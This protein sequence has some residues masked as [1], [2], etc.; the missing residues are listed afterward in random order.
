M[1][2]FLSRK[3][4][5][6]RAFL[7]GSG[8]AVALPLLDAMTPA[9]ARGAEV[10]KPPRRFVAVCATL[11]F[12]TPFLF[13]TET[14]K[15]YTPT[16]YLEPLKDYRERLSVISGLSHAEQSGANGHSSE[17]TWLTA[18][19]RPGLAGFKNS[20]S[21]DQVIAE[22]VGVQTRFPSLV[23]SLGSESLSWTNNGVPIPAEFSPAK[24]FQQLFVNGTPAEVTAQV[25]KLKR[26]QSILDTVQ[27]EA[28]KL[29]RQ[30]GPQDQHKLDEYLT[31]V[32]GLEDRLQESQAWATKPKPAVDAKP[33]TDIQNR[34]DAI[35]RARLMYDMIALAL[36]TDSTRTVTLRLSG[37]N[38]VPVVD[39]VKNDWHNLSHHGQDEA[40]I[41]ELKLIELAEFRAFADFL[42]RLKAATEDGAPLLDRTAVLYGSNL[43]NASSH[44]WRNLP[45]VLA[46]GGFKHPG[47]LAA[48]SPKDNVPL[49]NLFVSL[50]RHMG[51][52]AERFG[53]STATG[54]K[55]LELAAR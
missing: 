42:A 35:G 51:I 13:P 31:G 26:G 52:E 54:L 25:K 46:G 21:L 40:K 18:A 48:G 43:G 55:G 32:R 33:P 28:K 39:G 44:D 34:A 38:Q 37:L 2:A 9:L 47:H 24:L 6:R 30:L 17:L 50:L 22:K 41:A 14:G 23:L 1:P 12:H 10:T 4:L 19:K 45:L 53:G 49:S 16:P 8:A 5:S 7:R 11:G 29:D 36:Q 3:S 20:V 15:D 27:A